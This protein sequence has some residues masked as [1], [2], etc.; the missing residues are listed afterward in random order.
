[1]KSVLTIISVFAALSFWG[2]EPK[3]KLEDYR[4]ITVTGSASL[5]VPP[6]FVEIRVSISTVEKS[7]E[8]AFSNNATKVKKALSKLLEM[9]IPQKDVATNYVSLS[10]KEIER[11]N[12]APLFIGYEASQVI[13][14][15]LRD[16][17]KYDLLLT[18]IIGVGVDNIDSVT[19]CISNE[20]EKK[21]EARSLAINATK[22]KA[23]YMVNLLSQKLCA[24][25]RIIETPEFNISGYANVTRDKAPEVVSSSLVPSKITITAS[26]DITFMLCD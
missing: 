19:F 10:K 8:I 18:S 26:V 3:S 1:M 6:D 20:Q 22:E 7:H 14:I 23:E 24:P 15:I 9:G 4:Q 2:A 13:T 11:E 21:K 12:N 25:L 17:S 16:L 5:Q